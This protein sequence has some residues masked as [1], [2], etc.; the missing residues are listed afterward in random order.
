M[1]TDGAKLFLVMAVC[2]VAI[3]VFFD[4]LRAM[5]ITLKPC[6]A[7]TAV[8]DIL[9]VMVS[10]LMATGCVWNFGNGKF[11]FYEILG[12][13]LGGSLY[14]SLLSRFALRLF[15]F[16]TGK[17]LNFTRFIFK[18][19]LTP[20]LFLYK[21][22]IVPMKIKIRSIIQRSQGAYAKRIQRKGRR[23]HRKP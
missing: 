21:I 15:L 4:M 23:I 5:R 7:V 16:I 11:R 20:L 6:A 9:F 13:I 1:I 12:L 8:S 22:L 17:I 3:S 10:F 2:G 19:L 14:F 18:I